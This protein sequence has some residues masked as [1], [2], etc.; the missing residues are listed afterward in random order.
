MDQHY[1]KCEK[2]DAMWHTMT[3]GEDCP[4]C[5]LEIIQ[6]EFQILK[7]DND[8]TKDIMKWLSENVFSKLV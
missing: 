5:Q 8:K 7:D 3:N 6:K 4:F 2:H 1:S